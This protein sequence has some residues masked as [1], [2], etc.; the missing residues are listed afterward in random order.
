[1]WHVGIDLHRKTV[2]FAAINDAGEVRPPV[3]LDCSQVSEIVGAFEKLRPFRA[4]IEATRAYRWLFKFLSPLG[5]V[6]LTPGTYC[7]SALGPALHANRTRPKQ[8]RLQLLGE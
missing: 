7:I 2:V 5:T 1:M 4:V 6:L 3:R 8:A